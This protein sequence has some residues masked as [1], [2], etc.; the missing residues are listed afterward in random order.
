MDDIFSGL[1][2]KSAT[3]IFSA[4]FSENGLLAKLSCAAVL[5]TH[6]SNFPYPPTT[7]RTPPPL[8]HPPPAQLLPR[9]NTILVV[10]NGMI[11]HRGTYDELLANGG[12]D[13]SL[14]SRVAA[15]KASA[16]AGDAVEVTSDGKI[17]LKD[18]PLD[19][20]ENQASRA[21]SE[22]GVYSYFLKSCGVVGITLFFVLAAVLAGERSFE[23]E[24]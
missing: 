18:A 23:S 19:K 1:D 14:L 2:R 7:F 12:L 3:H 5:V 21:P 10:S 20:E 24:F 6:S 9:F 17:V 11:A 22:W 8:T 15:P 4:V 13:D 16:S